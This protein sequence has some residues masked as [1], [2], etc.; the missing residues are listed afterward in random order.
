M[1]RKIHG[2][3][4][5]SLVDTLLHIIWTEDFWIN[6]SIQY[7]DDPNRPCRYSEYRDWNSIVYYN[8]QVT[9]KVDKYLSNLRIGHLG[10]TV[11]RT[12]NDG[13]R[14]RWS[15]KVKD[16]LIHV[17]AE[18]LHNRGEII[19][20]LWLINIKPQDIGWLSVMKITIPHGQ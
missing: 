19:A 2:T 6:N 3:A 17:I 1:L 14:R 18:E 20:I 13:I 11:F 7:K 10:K 8:N 15:C 4:W 5:L 16:V 12:N 9:S